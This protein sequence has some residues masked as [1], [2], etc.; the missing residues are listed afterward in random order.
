MAAVRAAGARMAAAVVAAPAC[1]CH[2]EQI[3][4]MSEGQRCVDGSSVPAWHCWPA[5]RLPGT[6]AAQGTPP[7]TPPSRRS[8]TDARRR[9]RCR[10]GR[11]NNS[12]RGEPSRVASTVVEP[13]ERVAAEVDYLAAEATGAA[14]GEVVG[15]AVATAA[16]TVVKAAV[17][18]KAVVKEEAVGSASV[19][20]PPD[21]AT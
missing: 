2:T 19:L 1:G 18:A 7:G 11:C 14:A 9:D 10:H 20:P 5:R 3:A 12:G 6:R 13:S 17:K 4:H 21:P 8:V 16:V 15:S